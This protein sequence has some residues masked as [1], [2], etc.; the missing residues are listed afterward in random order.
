MARI[1]YMKT[2]S[3]P[4]DAASLAHCD[5]A[6]AFWHKVGHLRYVGWPVVPSR[7]ITPG[8]I[9]AWMWVDPQNPH[10]C[11]AELH[12]YWTLDP[13]QMTENILA[14]PTLQWMMESYDGLALAVEQHAFLS[15]GTL[16]LYVGGAGGD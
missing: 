2:F 14:D 8:N 7:R 5:E 9:S 12:L 1:D 15:G 10:V 6:K 13:L 16:K 11:H 4:H 3:W